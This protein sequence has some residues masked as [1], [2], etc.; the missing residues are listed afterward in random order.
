MLA[1]TSC[2][3]GGLQFLKLYQRST[4]SFY[5]KDEKTHALVD[6]FWNLSYK[7]LDPLLKIKLGKNV[8]DRWS[9]KISAIAEP[10]NGQAAFDKQQPCLSTVCLLMLP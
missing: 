4:C 6:Y 9:L 1:N 8:G 7:T 10:G 3:L 5:L 2:L